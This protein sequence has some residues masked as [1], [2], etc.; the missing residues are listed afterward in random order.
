MG[1]EDHDLGPDRRT[2]VNEG[3]TVTLTATAPTRGRRPHVGHCLGVRP[4][5]GARHGGTVPVQLTVPG[6]HHITATVADSGGQTRA[7]SV[8]VTVYSAP[9]VLTI[10][11]PADGFSTPER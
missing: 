3:T 2:G 5:G 9:P 8:A 7:G 6:V 10:V 4:A 1:A 11:A